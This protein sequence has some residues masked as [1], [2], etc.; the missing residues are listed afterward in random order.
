MSIFQKR[1]IKFSGKIACDWNAVK[2]KILIL[3]C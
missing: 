1:E 2:P 3:S